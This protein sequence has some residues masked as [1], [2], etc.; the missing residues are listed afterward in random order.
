MI[1]PK[2]LSEDQYLWLNSNPI[3][4]AELELLGRNDR[5]DLYKIL[6]RD[7]EGRVH[8]LATRSGYKGF[9]LK[10]ED[11]D[12]GIVYAAK[13]CVAEDYDDARDEFIECKL[14]AQLKR[15]GDLFV[16]PERVGRVE[17]FP[18]MP[19][20]QDKFVCFVSDWIEGNTIQQI[21]S[22]KAP[23]PL[24]PYVICA[25]IR[26]V[27]RAVQF[28]KSKQLKHDDLHWGNIMVRP[29]DPAL[30][31]SESERFDRIISIIDMGSLKPITQPTLK[32]KDD[33]LY[34]I[35]LIVNL[36]NSAFLNRSL[37]A[38]NPLFFR[39]L[40]NLAKELADEDHLRHYEQNNAKKL[41]DLLSAIG[42]SPS[43]DS[44]VAFHPFEAI[45]AEHLADDS[46]LLELFVGT[47][48]WFSQAFAPKPLVLT[49]PR[50]CGKSMLF[51]YMAARSHDQNVRVEEEDRPSAPKF[52]GV[53]ISCATHLQNSLM[54]LGRKPGRIEE[55]ASAITTFFGLVVARELFRALANAAN[56]PATQEYFGLDEKNID[57]FIDDIKQLFGQEI[58]SPRLGQKS[59]ALHFADDLDRARIR[60]QRNLLESRKPFMLLGD[61]FI[62]DMISRL[63]E[64]L[65]ILSF[66]KIVFLL[67]D[68][69]SSRVHP[70]IQS[71]LTKIIFER[72]PSRY[73]KISCEKFGFSPNDIDNVRIDADREYEVIDAGSQASFDMTGAVKREF[74]TK[75]IDRRLEIAKWEGRT[76]T[77]LGDSGK[78]KN[79]VC[80][81]K[82]IRT[83]G[84]SHGRHYYYYGVDHLSRLWSGDIATVLQMVRDIFIR[85]NIGQRSTELIPHNV[86]HD[87]IVQVSRAFRDRVAG[88]YPF[89]ERM[90]QILTAFGNMGREI[91][92]NG[93]LTKAG[94]P[95]RLIRIE[96][97]RPESVQL[98]SLI[99]DKS[100][101]AELLAK[102]LLRRGVFI[103]YS[104]SRGK[105]GVG[106]ETT[107]W[108][109]R[110]IYLPSFGM[111]LIR[112]SYIDVKT[113]EH[114]MDLLIDPNK[115][116]SVRQAQY[117]GDLNASLFEEPESLVSNVEQQDIDIDLEEC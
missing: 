59:R 13:I 76:A 43:E 81:A 16:I 105:E 86:Q 63:V 9:V 58:E 112:N 23:I 53:Y 71:I 104:D 24:D 37:A 40:R 97:T 57:N 117:Q 4:P 2:E 68:Y 34:L 46:V 92:V 54:W 82:H 90:A 77:L 18:G 96:M 102:E 99:R 87:S 110:K 69:S 100:V 66:R 91:L 64:F 101:E 56:N 79:D 75:L 106:T 38:E 74:I 30:I 3:L 84:S 70:G 14:S 95:R 55:N 33:E 111:A 36:F 32:S 41:D 103:E 60:I 35:D 45:S 61:S 72:H 107:R 50:G 8:S 11:H 113:V 20:P 47:L 27:L 93:S 6:E 109:L 116:K 31:L 88:Y 80:L 28:L 5:K 62:S 17:R 19:G 25:A 78:M 108:Q 1:A 52:F 89:G 51:R 15:A 85:A 115:F 83:T 94:Q 73:F 98:L 48:P 29:K 26:E 7:G 21:A 65:P 39:K 114:F 49:G 44:D 22:G 67:D 12:T 10:V 42:K